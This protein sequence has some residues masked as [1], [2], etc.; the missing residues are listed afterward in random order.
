M[1][2]ARRASEEGG[3]AGGETELKNQLDVRAE[4]P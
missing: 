1:R 4:S 3:T 2:A